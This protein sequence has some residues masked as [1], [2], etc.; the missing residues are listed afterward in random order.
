MIAKTLLRVVVGGL[1]AGHGAQKLFGSFG[2]RGLEETGRTFE[3]LELR[4]GREM[5][6]LAGTTELAGG[7]LVALGA[8]TPYGAA[9][10]TGVMATAIE[11][12]HLRNGPWNG[13]GGYEY[14]LVLMAVLFQLT[15]SGPGPVSVDRLRGKRHAGPGWA[16]LEL[17]AGIAG[18]MAVRAYSTRRAGREPGSAGQPDE[19][20]PGEPSMAVDARSGERLATS[21]SAPGGA[22][23]VAG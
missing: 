14:P 20:I 3:R 8:G 19:R 18:A 1:F 16:V 9:M 13:D 6:A 11:R 12:A 23:T 2:G 21:G 15:D 7:T 4:P 17:A 10:L 5:A 22:R